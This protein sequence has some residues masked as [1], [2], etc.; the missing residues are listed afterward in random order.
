M[1]KY[2]R[3]VV[4]FC[5]KTKSLSLQAR[6]KEAVRLEVKTL[7]SSLETKVPLCVCLKN[8]TATASQTEINLRITTLVTRGER[9]GGANADLQPDCSELGLITNKS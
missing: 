8:T 9:C 7:D 4:V 5:Q 3:E 2:Q 1:C 6:R